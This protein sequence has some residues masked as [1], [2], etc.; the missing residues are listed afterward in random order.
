METNLSF[1]DHGLDES[2]F[3]SMLGILGLFANQ[4]ILPATEDS[5]RGA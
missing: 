1:L 4:E 5:S 3:T 2:V